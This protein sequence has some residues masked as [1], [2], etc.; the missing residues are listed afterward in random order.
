MPATQGWY[1]PSRYTRAPERTECSR[2][3][4]EFKAPGPVAEERCS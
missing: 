3:A 4:V 1:L 2:I